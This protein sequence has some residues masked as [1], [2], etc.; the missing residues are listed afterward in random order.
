MSW[1]SNLFGGHNKN[2]AKSAMPYLDQ[3]PGQ[4]SPYYQP[5]QQAGAGALADLQKQYGSLL[6]D[7]GAMYKKF[8]EGY[9]QSPGYQFKLQQGLDAA[10]NASAMGGQL[11]TPQHQ[12]LDTQVTQGIANQDFN[13]YMQNIMGLYGQGLQ[14]E[15]GLNTMGYGANTDYAQ[16]LAQ[17]GG[18]K[19]QYAFGGQAGQNQMNS[20]SM[21][22]L[23][24]LIGLLGP[25]AMNYFFPK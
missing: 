20:Q 25:S 1:L 18:N 10:N 2:P 23:M 17:L 3:I 9:Q 13:D 7:P 6:N 21:S 16:M 22:N 15:Q 12:Q 24:G 5:Y 11:G 19:A 4:V 8:G 14:G